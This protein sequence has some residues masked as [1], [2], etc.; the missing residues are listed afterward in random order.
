MTAYRS[1]Y[2]WSAP[3]RN[4]VKKDGANARAGVKPS[5]HPSCNVGDRSGRVLRVVSVRAGTARPLHLLHDIRRLA[6]HRPSSKERSKNP[7]YA[8]MLPPGRSLNLAHCAPF[9]YQP[10]LHHQQPR[11]S[12]RCLGFLAPAATAGTRFARTVNHEEKCK[13][14]SSCCWR[15]A[16]RKTPQVLNWEWRLGSCSF[17]Q[18]WAP[19]S[20]SQPPAGGA[21]LGQWRLRQRMSSRWC[22][23]GPL[24][25]VRNCHRQRLLVL[26]RSSPQLGFTLFSGHIVLLGSRNTHLEHS[27]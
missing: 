4:H 12:F 11:I 3:R 20:P 5:I 6:K 18:V 13:G 7:P 19:S 25:S 10:M 26:S 17:L 16:G 2:V 14:H 1:Q 22:P 23:F 9:E 24:R 15:I 27:F 21:R 8:R